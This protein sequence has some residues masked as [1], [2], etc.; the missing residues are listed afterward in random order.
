MNK[1]ISLIIN[2]N[3]KQETFANAIVAANAKALSVFKQG[4]SRIFVIHSTESREY[5][6][7]ISTEK[8]QDQSTWV[9]HISSSSGITE[10]EFN[11]RTIDLEP[12]QTSLNKLVEYLEFILCN[13]VGNHQIMVDLSNGKV[14]YRNMLAVAAYVLNITHQYM[15][16]ITILQKS[17]EG[18]SISNLGFLPT[19]K[20]EPAYTPMPKSTDLDQIAYIDLSEMIR[21]KQKAKKYRGKYNEIDNLR[22]A[23]F[24]QEN[25]LQSLSLKL[26]ADRDDGLDLASYRIA[27]ATI[28]NSIEDL[29]DMLIERFSIEPLLESSQP[30]LGKKLNAIKSKL[31]TVA[32]GKFDKDLLMHLNQL[33]LHLRNKSVH[34]NAGRDYKEFQKITSDISMKLS[35][36][37]IEYYTDIIHP[38][39]TG[40]PE[41]ES[42][43]T[44]DVRELSPESLIGNRN[45]Y[46][47]LDGDDTGKI[48]EVLFQKLPKEGELKAW[49]N[50][51]QEAITQVVDCVKKHKEARIIFEAGDNLLFWGCF[52]HKELE[53]MQK[54]YH[55]VM[56]EKATCSIGFGHTLTEVNYALKLAKFREGKSAIVGVKWANR[57]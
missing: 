15:I 33:V 1:T 18:M 20:L 6:A 46:F 14:I 24:F 39:L 56:Q 11:Y 47:S 54:I 52:K 5:F 49:S 42:S 41:V 40:Q 32:S 16:D 3:T 36:V 9:N 37:F 4:L 2:G 30:T 50:K 45:F 55:E 57:K 43:K 35:L 13:Q 10:E 26:H 38:L 19:D 48:F 23:R 28:A 17:L 27:S 25:L 31:E 34:F 7:Q 53:Q 44:N 12:N 8:N 51:I 21:Y 22:D 29:L